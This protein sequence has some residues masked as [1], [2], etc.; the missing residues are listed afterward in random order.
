MFPR[1]H[2]SRKPSLS[3]VVLN[4]FGRGRNSELR[5]IYIFGHGRNSLF[6]VFSSSAAAEIPFRAHFTFSATAETSFSVYSHLRPW[7]ENDFS[8]KCE[9]L[10]PKKRI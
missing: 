8:L 5:D 1:L 2:L 3:I 10:P 4:S 7:T 9:H 6:I